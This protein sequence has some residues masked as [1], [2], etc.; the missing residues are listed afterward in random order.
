MKQRVLTPAINGWAMLTMCLVCA[1]ACGSSD[2][3]GS[4]PPGSGGKSNS[5]GHGGSA[6]ANG[7]GGRG[8]APNVGGANGDPGNG[9][10]GSGNVGSGV[11]GAG[12]AG[13]DTAGSGH[14]GSIANGG[15]GGSANLGGA[16]GS[17]GKSSSA[18]T[19]LLVPAS[20]ALLGQYYGDGDIEATKVKLGRSLP[21][22]LTYWAWDDDWTSGATKADIAAGRIPLV[23][24]E[25]DGIDFATIVNGSQDATIKA[26]AAGAKAL[27]V[28]FFLDFAAEMN[29]DEA[30]SGNDAKL[31]VDA[32]RHIHDLF[33]A[34]GATNVVWA[35]CPNVVDTDG[36]NKATLSYYPGDSYVDWTGVDGYNWGADEWQSFHDVFRDI[37]P[38]LA[39]KKKPIL[40]GEMASSP[41]GGDKAAWIDAIIPSLQ[42]DFPLIKGVIW[43][44][45]KKE[46]DWRISSSSA[47]ESAFRTLAADPFFS[48]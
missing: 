39:G 7:S 19:D 29:G 10:G 44:D 21:V 15:S 22:H 3:T 28:Q 30:W 1:T 45:V 20:G 46:R 16:A 12:A 24:W 26:R 2:A 34:A 17:A 27:K 25:P 23:N 40:I 35:W 38:L 6:T 42:Q 13:N 47:S 4:A 36:T 9:N 31:Y 14:G 8:D 37:Y 48:H 41:T 11:G 43:F 18:T 5:S 33:V 32:Y